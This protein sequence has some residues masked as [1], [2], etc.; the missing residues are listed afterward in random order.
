M[1]RRKG[2]YY[3][4]YFLESFDKLI[5]I[6]QMCVNQK[7]MAVDSLR[8][9]KVGSDSASICPSDCSGHGVCNSLG[10]LFAILN[11]CIKK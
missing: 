10:M 9:S 1:W 4:K 2:E 5:N 6:L 11:L 7:C 3:K 8:L